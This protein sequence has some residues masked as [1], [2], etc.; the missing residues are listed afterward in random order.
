M[1]KVLA[2]QLVI[3]TCC[4]CSPKNILPILR[5]TDDP[6]VPHESCTLQPLHS[7]TKIVS[8]V[9]PGPFVKNEWAYYQ[10]HESE[11]LQGI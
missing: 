8:Q 5:V 2:K 10:T 9:I 11:I 6:V 4:V 1:Q 3:D 7:L